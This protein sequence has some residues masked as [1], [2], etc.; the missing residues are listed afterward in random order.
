MSGDAAVRFVD[1]C[2]SEARRRFEAL[3][4]EMAGRSAVASLTRNDGEA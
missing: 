2:E 3:R 1:G 4:S